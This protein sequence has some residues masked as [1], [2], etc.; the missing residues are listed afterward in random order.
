MGVIIGAGVYLGSWLD[1]KYSNPDNS[2]YTIIFSL[3]AVF[4]ALYNVIRQV[5]NLGDKS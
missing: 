5:K 1:S 2:I 3:L 4:I